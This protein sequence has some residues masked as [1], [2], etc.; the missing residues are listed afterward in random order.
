M[1]SRYLALV[2]LFLVCLA[3]RS[4]Y[5]LLKEAGKIDL[6]NKIIFGFIFSAMCTLWICWFALCSL[7]PFRFEIPEAVPWSGLALFILGMILALGA[8]MQL[9]GLENIDHLV[10]TGLFARLRHPMYTGFIL[11]ILGWSIYHGAFV[12]LAVGV[13]A[14]ANIL[15]WRHLE[16]SRLLARYGEV[17]QKYRQRTWF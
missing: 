12:S 8:L 11:W 2:I 5:E 13:I 10:T 4:T 7:D 14:I 16:D 6:E 17:Y 9:R 3:I 1:D 15:Y